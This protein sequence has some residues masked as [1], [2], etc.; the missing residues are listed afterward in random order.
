MAIATVIAVAAIAV[1]ALTRAPA[2]AQASGNPQLSWVA[3]AAIDA[4][5]PFADPTPVDAMSCPSTTLCI[6]TGVGGLL[7][8]S[9]TPTGPASGWSVLPS[10]LIAGSGDGYAIDS[11]SCASTAF[12]EVA[13]FSYKEDDGAVLTSTDPAGGAS[14]W[15]LN[16]ISGAARIVAVQCLAVSACFAVDDGGDVLAESNGTWSI[17]SSAIAKAPPFTGLACVTTGPSAYEC[18]AAD[19]G[20]NIYESTTPA[21][22]TSTSW[23]TESSGLTNLDGGITCAGTG[24]FCLEQSADGELSSKGNPLSTT[25]SPALASSLTMPITCADDPAATTTLDALCFSGAAGTNGIYEMGLT[26][27]GVTFDEDAFPAN[28]GDPSAVSCPSA[29]TCVAGTSE[30]SVT[31]ATAASGSLSDWA[32]ATWSPGAV[33]LQGVNDLALSPTSCPSSTLCVAFDAA[34]RVL[35]STDPSGGAAAWSS[36][37]VD[38]AP[39]TEMTCPSTS[40][41]VGVDKRGGI[42]SSTD[43]A[44]GPGSFTVSSSSVD[45]HRPQIA[46][47][48]VTLC[49]GL[50]SKGDVV[51]SSDPAGGSS[52]WTVTSTSVDQNAPSQPTCP[53]ASLCVADDGQ[54]TVLASGAPAGGSGTWSSDDL[55]GTNEMAPFSCPNASLCVADDG[56]GN[57]ISSTDPAAGASSFTVAKGVAPNGMAVPVQCPSTTLCVGLD[58]KGDLVSSTNPAGGASAWS[59]TS[60][61]VG[62]ADAQALV[63]PTAALCIATDSIGDVY[64]STDPAD[65]SSWTSESVDAGHALAVATCASATLCLLADD[66][67]ELIAGQTPSSG[68]GSTGGSTGGG[69]TGGGSTGGGSTGGGSKPP[70][71]GVLSAAKASVKSDTVT[72]K[73]KCTGAASSRCAAAAITLTATETLRAGRVIAVAAAAKSPTTKK[74]VTFAAKALTLSSGH[75]SVLKLTL[76]AAGRSLLAHLGKL[77]VTLAVTQGKH[78]VSRQKLKLVRPAPSRTR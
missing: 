34:G 36:A 64:E 60:G 55:D 71:A 28:T 9:Q 15:T 12:C 39:I 5:A 20:G 2:P 74:T 66:R 57:I 65:P 26:K 76:N 58:Q 49:V 33:V 16:T 68:G 32:D 50:D 38:S 30:G 40:L 10:K 13:G 73:L 72:V 61:P 7:A 18:G 29:T 3:P 4:A 78:T 47:P 8:S 51:S 21:N 56:V 52:A 70:A 35:T 45:A 27:T 43:P 6:A 63:C 14:D 54:G 42:I 48:T 22:L 41:C 69:S 17:S 67:D 53:T 75:T 62:P 19:S 46:C 1:I 59:V 24:P 77:Q 31:S 11:A 23:Q 44:T 37:V 25:F